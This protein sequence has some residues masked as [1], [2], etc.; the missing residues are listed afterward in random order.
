MKAK[1]ER[2]DTMLQTKLSVVKALD[3]QVLEICKTTDI[4]KKVEDADEIES[5]VLDMRNLI[6]ENRTK[7][8]SK[9]KNISKN[10]AVNHEKLATTNEI[11]SPNLMEFQSRQTIQNLESQASLSPG[12]SS[13][14]QQTSDLH[15]GNLLVEQ[16][17]ILAHQ[18]TAS[19][20]G[21]GVGGSNYSRSD[22]PKLGLPKF[23]EI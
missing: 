16:S 2:I 5:R 13:V 4:L 17:N 11:H 22:L 21:G 23:K 15:G 9:A 14:V 19:F 20:G 8:F 7:S 12:T 18:N 3:E 1:L 6:P 10:G